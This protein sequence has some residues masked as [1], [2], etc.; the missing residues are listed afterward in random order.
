VRAL[1]SRAIARLAGAAHNPRM[2]GVRGWPGLAYWL[3]G[4][5]A[6]GLVAIGLLAIGL[7][8]EDEEPRETTLQ[9][10]TPGEARPDHLADG[11]PIWVIGHQDGTV[12]VLSG[13]DTHVPGVR[14]LLWWCPGARTLEDPRHGSRW[15][16]TG[17]RLTGPAPAPLHTWQ[18]TPRGS[19]LFVGAPQ[20]ATDEPPVEPVGLHCVGEDPVSFHEF[21]GWDVWSSPRAAVVAGQPGWFLLDGRLVPQPDGTVWLCALTGC[22]DAVPADWIRAPDP[23]VLALDP[24]P[25][26]RYLARARDGRLTDLAQIIRRED[27]RPDG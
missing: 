17:A 24:W 8:R 18:T 23:E 14:K 21:P 10:P 3:I 7:L 26:T 22:D 19:R 20:P 2:N 15:D 25:D 1:P 11:T 4:L 16:E 5:L 13:I 27:L 12:T 9:R 6:L